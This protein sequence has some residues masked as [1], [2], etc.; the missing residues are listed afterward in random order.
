MLSLLPEIKT[1]LRA[2]KMTS[3]CYSHLRD[4]FKTQPAVGRRFRPVPPGFYCCK[5]W[6]PP[7][8]GRNRWSTGGWVLKPP[9]SYHLCN[10]TLSIIWNDYIVVI[11]WFDDTSSWCSKAFESLILT[12]GFLLLQ[13]ERR[14]QTNKQIMLTDQLLIC[15]HCISRIF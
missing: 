5:Q 8:T 9:L 13:L 4:G 3:P 12:I 6:Q 14:K 1:L 11:Y 7:G 15:R 2:N 10:S